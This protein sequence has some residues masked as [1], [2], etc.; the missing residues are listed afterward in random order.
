MEILDAHEAAIS[1]KYNSFIYILQH[2]KTGRDLR[3]QTVAA[4]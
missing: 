3:V 4:C 1:V 2:R